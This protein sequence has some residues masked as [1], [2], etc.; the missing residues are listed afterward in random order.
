MTNIHPLLDPEKQRRARRY[1]MEKRGLGLLAGILSAI[2]LLAFYGT[3]LSERIAQSFPGR[4]IVWPF[5]ISL[6]SLLGMWTLLSLPLSF[7]SGYRHEHKWNFSN[8]TLKSWS[9]E[10]LKSFIVTLVISS[11]LLGLLLWIMARFPGSGG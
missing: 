7:Y 10:K 3:G 9:L 8:Q 6:I 4:S 5:L 11:L 1:E 2:V